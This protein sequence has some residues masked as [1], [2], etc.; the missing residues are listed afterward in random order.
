M[1]IVL[2]KLNDELLANLA[3]EAGTFCSQ[4]EAAVAYAHGADHPLLRTCK[5][6]GLRLV[7]YGLL[8]EEGAVGIPFLKELLS[9]GPS[10]AEVRLVKWNF[11]PKVIWWRGF[12]AYV[13]SA[14]VTDKAWFNNVE[15]GVFL[16]ESELVPCPS[17]STSTAFTTPRAAT[18]PSTTSAPSNLSCYSP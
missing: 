13:G 16:D 1:R 18:R 17:A 8:D 15:A 10:R 7:F 9:W 5:E 3:L 2:G 12:G 4:V 6:R 14:N 11:H